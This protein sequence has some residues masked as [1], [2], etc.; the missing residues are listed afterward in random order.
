MDDELRRLEQRIRAGQVDLIPAYGQARIRSGE[1]WVEAADDSILGS[2]W[3]LYNLG[4]NG[5][6][7]NI[8]H[9]RG[10]LNNGAERTVD[11]HLED[12]V[13]NKDGVVMTSPVID[14]S[15]KLAMY[16]HR[17]HSAF[18]GTVREYAKDQLR[19]EIRERVAARLTLRQG[20][21][22]TIE[23][24]ALDGKIFVRQ[25]AVPACQGS[26]FTLA[27]EQQE[28]KLAV[29]GSIQKNI[30]PFLV[31]LMG[32]NYRGVI[33]AIQYFTARRNKK[34]SEVALFTPPLQ[35]RRE[36]FERAVVLCRNSQNIRFGIDVDCA[37]EKG[38]P[39]L[40]W[41]RLE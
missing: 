35:F 6:T 20:E 17:N 31:D 5:E 30:A 4:V 37:V 40:G 41:R 23:D 10:F 11:Q 22:T 38:R 21:Q 34:L 3:K 26:Y 9:S 32:S 29:F 27:R 1:F 33:F 15:F 24:I 14:N 39:A 36:L 25:V 7:A 16:Q 28:Y 13:Q 8:I 2:A 12:S 19:N 18:E